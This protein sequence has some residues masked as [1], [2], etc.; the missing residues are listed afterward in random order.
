MKWCK[1]GAGRSGESDFTLAGGCAVEWRDWDYEADAA[2]ADKANDAV[3]VRVGEVRARVIGE[4][5]N[6]GITP[7]ARVELALRGVALNSDALDNSAGVSASDH[8]VNIKILL[9]LLEREG[10]LAPAARAK[11][12]R[13]MTEDVAELVLRDNHLQ[14]VALSLMASEDA[15]T[16][17][18]LQPWQQFLVREGWLD[19]AVDALPA[20]ADLSERPGGFYSRPEL[21]AL[22]AGTK[23]WLRAELLRDKEL[24]ACAAVR[25]L[26]EQYFPPALR[27]HAKLMARHPLAAEI[28]ATV[29]A[30][31]VVNR[32]G[33]LAIR[34]LSE[35]CD[36]GAAAAVRACVVAYGVARLMPLWEE[37]DSLHMRKVTLDTTL[38]VMR[39]LQTLTTFVAGWILRHGE[40][41]DVDRW[42]KCLHGP[43]SEIFGLLPTLLAKRVE[44]T[45]WQREWR[46][47]GLPAAMAGQLAVLSPFVVA[48]D[49]VLLREVSRQPLAKVLTLHLQVG[50][51][52]RLPAL[53]GKVR[54]MPVP[55]KWARQAVQAMVQELF[56]R[57]RRLTERLLRKNSD[58]PSWLVVC[59][60]ACRRYHGLVDNLLAEPILTVAMLSVVLGRLRELEG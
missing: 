32:L 41:V 58:V 21:C 8:E 25:P 34:R 22:L 10:G 16:H 40:A 31:M 47:L 57:Q 24:L 45:Q 48:P 36:V 2:V 35:D 42:L 56:L 9:R 14:N 26:L 60:E 20:A 37:L 43:C 50:E 28:V 13:G 29:L 11:L 30:N 12:L 39:R 52:L 17:A 18:E 23:L 1:C 59:G 3:R 44:M 27:R 55:D 6:L 51:A 7:R 15:A 53:V 5:G 54:A 33:I 38:R 19:K 4:G 49:T 46:G